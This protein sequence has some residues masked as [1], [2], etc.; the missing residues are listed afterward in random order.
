MD[1]IVLK[2]LV[3]DPNYRYQSADEMRADIEACLDGQPVAA[4]AALG[5]VGYGGYPDDQPTTALR[6]EPGAGAT[7]MLPPMN[8]DDGGYGYD[9]RPDRRRQQPKKS[10]TSTILLVVAGVLVLIGAILIG[11]WAF[12]GHN[13]GD[14]KVEV[15]TF[16]GQPLDTAR[17][18]ADN[19]DLKVTV[20]SRKPCA[21]Q[22]KGNVCDQD[23]APKTNVA[24][25]TTIS[26]TV[27]TG[28]PKVTVP[29]V[30]GI[31]FDQAQS[32]LE[33]KGFKVERKDVVSDQTPGVVTKQDPAGGTSKQKGSVITLTVAKAA[34]KVTVPDDL[35][36]KSCDDAK[37]EL[38]QLG[39]TPTCNDTPTNNPDDNGKVL[40]TNP[41]AGQQVAKN[42]PIAINVGKVQN[43]QVQVPANLQG[44]KLKDAKQ[45]LQQAGL[46]VGNIQGSQ[47]DNA[48][49]FTSDPAPGST[50]NQ[51]TTVNLVTVGGQGGNNN[52]GNNGGTNFFGGVTG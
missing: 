40:S 48:I 20:G 21:D 51:G 35:I 4:T 24:K 30:R 43:S 47:D 22:P 1:A 34:E 23:P 8:P 45:L 16:V 11:K 6:Q 9:E 32:Q 46:Q 41:P 17:T 28:A 19:V 5:A 2:A 15:P 25:G 33:D 10:N 29:D 13:A 37:A 7:T 36:G 50:V 31:Q 26:L 38:Q 18:M 44:Q 14:G 49:V 42:T 52:G 27:S 39:L 3:K 12:S